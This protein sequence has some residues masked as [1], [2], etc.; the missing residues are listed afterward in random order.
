M[1]VSLSAYQIDPK[2]EC[3][4]LDL[5]T[6]VPVRPHEAFEQWKDLIQES[7]I[8][9]YPCAR[10]LAQA[11]AALQGLGPDQ[12]AVTA[13]ADDAIDRVFRCTLA[14]GAEV[15]WNTPGFSMFPRYAEL[16]GATLVDV[17]WLDGEF[18]RGEFSDVI[19]DE[20]AL[21][22]LV[23]PQNPT[24]KSIPV[25]DIEALLCA[26]PDKVVLLDEAYIEFAGNSAVDLISRYP[27]LVVLRTLS[28]AY[29]AAGLRVGFALGQSDLIAKIQAAGSPFPVSGPS[30][31]IAR[32]LIASNETSRQ[33]YL[34]QVRVERSYLM[35]LALGLGDRAHAGHSNAVLWRSKQASWIYD[36]LTSL[37]I[38]IRRWDAP[39]AVNWVRIGCPGNPTDFERLRS[40]IRKV[41]QPNLLLLD[42]DGVI[43]DV[44]ASY[45]FAIKETAKS[46]G[47]ELND[48]QIEARKAQGR[49]NDDWQLTHALLED[50]GCSTSIESVIARFESIYQDGE[51]PDGL[52]RKEKLL[53]SVELLEALSKRL[54]LGIVTGRPR[55][56]AEQSLAL[57][58]IDSFFSV[59]VCREDAAL[60]PEPEPILL[61]MKRS[62]VDEPR[63]WYVG[64]TP[65]DVYAARAAGCVPIGHLPQGSGTA[66]RDALVQTGVSRV[67]GSLS[68]LLEMIA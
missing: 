50:A 42:M 10:E 20:T 25:S 45:R 19:R 44:A 29:G 5:C 51:F 55:R 18:P 27:L 52:W 17:P 37:G 8:R 31:R 32:E 30:L 34:E 9:R 56:D 4:D 14:A 1:S 39:E 22:V 54:P 61:A 2:A 33:R 26:Y 11:Y 15:V 23:S 3:C 66:I 62:L 12:V 43:F 28:K 47:V 21:L 59:V 60:K 36:A 63:A 24:G 41:R 53:A 16:C 67:L 35:D 65:D 46:F 58:Q 7:D 68:E 57:H 38:A 49:A 6:G 13:G 40:A 64:D 48:A